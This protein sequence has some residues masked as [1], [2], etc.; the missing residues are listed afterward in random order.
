MI[1]R[2]CS[3][4]VVFYA[5]KVLLVENDRGE[6][7]LPKGKIVGDGL[8]HE[9]AIQRVKL[10][11]GVD[12]RIL[13]IAGDTIYEFFSRSRNQR[14]CNAIMWYV[15]EAESVE[16]DISKEFLRGGFYKVS[17]ALEML[18]HSKE[19]SLVDVSYKKYKNYKKN[20]T[21]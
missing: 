15:M 7:T 21:N 16:L 6:W 12:A 18:T 2:R 17:E 13:D 14:V 20:D 5:N 4:G 9:S 8:P 3:G 1:V 10:E 11:T 19:K